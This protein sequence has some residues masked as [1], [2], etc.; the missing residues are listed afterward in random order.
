MHLGF[1]AAQ[2]DASKA[3]ESFIYM[4]PS[5]RGFT[6]MHLERRKATSQIKRLKAVYKRVKA[7]EKKKG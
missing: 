6:K 1:Q 4:H 5:I 7:K 2:T 3:E